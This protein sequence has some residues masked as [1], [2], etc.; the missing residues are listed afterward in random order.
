MV[1]LVHRSLNYVSFGGK[2]ENHTKKMHPSEPLVTTVLPKVKDTC[3]AWQLVR[4]G[5]L[6]RFIT[7]VTD[8]T[9]TSE[10]YFK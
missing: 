6:H 2:K 9:N 3:S 5:I 8:I 1:S 4:T 7:Y 10:K